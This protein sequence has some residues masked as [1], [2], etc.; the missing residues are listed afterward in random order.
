MGKLDLSRRKNTVSITKAEAL[1]DEGKVRMLDAT[2]LTEHPC[3]Q[4]IYGDCSSIDEVKASIE[5]NGMKGNPIIV[6]HRDNK[7]IIISGHT[8]VKAAI[9]LQIKKVQCQIYEQL[10]ELDENDLLVDYNL[11][12][13]HSELNPAV[14]A[15][16]LLFKYRNYLQRI[17]TSGSKE[18]PMSLFELG[19]KYFGYTKTEFYRIKNIAEADSGIQQLVEKGAVPYTALDELSGLTQDEQKEVAAKIEAKIEQESSDTISAKQAKN[20]IAEVKPKEKKQ[21]KQSEIINI[22]VDEED[23]DD[24]GDIDLS[25]LLEKD[26]SDEE[27]GDDQI[28]NAINHLYTLIGNSQGYEDNQRIKEA[29]TALKIM[30]EQELEEMQ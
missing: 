10:T 5:R 18:K 27:M 15:R 17:E 4:A 28:I 8:R 22:A 20:I 14:K 1:G 13:G 12:R 19:T 2:E 29:Y 3:Q 11:Q 24:Y 25:D 21:K 30:I 23:E 9:E 16:E 7:Y 6:S 26:I